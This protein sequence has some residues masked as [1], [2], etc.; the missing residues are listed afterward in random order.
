[1]TIADMAIDDTI[2]RLTEQYGANLESLSNQRWLL[3]SL[4]ATDGM[5]INEE[6]FAITAA[7]IA[8]ELEYLDAPARAGLITA[9]ADGLRRDASQGE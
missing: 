1:M 7:Q 4:L 6:A 9:I 3:I 8:H 2:A 5:S